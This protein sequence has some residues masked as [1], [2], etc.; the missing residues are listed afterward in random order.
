MASDINAHNFLWNPHCYKEKNA[1][2]LERF[3]EQYRL[4]INNKPRQTTRSSSWKFLVI[5]SVLFTA[6]L[7]Y[8]TLWEILKEYPS[9]LNHKL[10]VA[11]SKDIDYDSVKRSIKKMTNW[12]T[13]GLFNDKTSLKAAQKHW[14]TKT[15]NW[16]I[17]QSSCSRLK[18]DKKEK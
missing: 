16:L 7:D 17:L 11:C 10:L 14:I 6:E 15:S 5:N 4:L 2:I 1:T 12:D 3:I 13:H 18:L 9:L 8:L